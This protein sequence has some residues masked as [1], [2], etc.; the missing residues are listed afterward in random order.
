MVFLRLAQTFYFIIGLWL[1]RNHVRAR[2]IHEVHCALSLPGETFLP[3][4]VMS[5]TIEIALDL[6][7]I[8]QITEISPT[9]EHEL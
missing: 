2:A 1:L 9:D 3:K 4:I 6:D 5:K 8:D 7:E